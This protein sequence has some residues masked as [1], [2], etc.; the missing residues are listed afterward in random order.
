MKS[1]LIPLAAALVIAAAGPAY[2]ETASLRYD[3]LDLFTSAGKATFDARVEQTLRA[4]CPAQ[5]L[6]GTRISNDRGTA[7]CNSEAR[8][9]IAAQLASRGGAGRLAAQAMTRSAALD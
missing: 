2:A 1:T 5:T 8:K 6:T 9:Q 4:A 3:D 7:E